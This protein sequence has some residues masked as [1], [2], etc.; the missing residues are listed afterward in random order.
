V[1]VSSAAAALAFNAFVA[2][3][4]VRSGRFR[5]ALAGWRGNDTDDIS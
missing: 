5:A 1:P 4:V 2:A 3:I